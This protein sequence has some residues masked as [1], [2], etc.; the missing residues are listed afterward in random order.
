M[1]GALYFFINPLGLKVKFYGYYGEKVL[2]TDIQIASIEN[3]HIQ[4]A[5]ENHIP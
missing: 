3:A 1:A 5:I 2:L 4:Y